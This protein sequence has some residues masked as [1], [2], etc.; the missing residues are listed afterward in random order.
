MTTNLKRL[1]VQLK[2]SGEGTPQNPLNI[3]TLGLSGGMK[4]FFGLFAETQD[5]IANMTKCHVHAN[6]DTVFSLQILSNASC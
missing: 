4:R 5:L 2:N 3:Q 1:A 6:D